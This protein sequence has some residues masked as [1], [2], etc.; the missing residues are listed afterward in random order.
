MSKR[1]ANALDGAST[2][3]K[4]SIPLSDYANGM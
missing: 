4:E 1:L 2:V 3:Y